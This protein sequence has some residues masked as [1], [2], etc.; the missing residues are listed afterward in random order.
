MVGSL[1][2]D[3]IQY[4]SY[5]YSGYVDLNF[6]FCYYIYYTSGFGFHSSVEHNLL[7]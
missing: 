3:Y 1:T 2:W 5:S 6:F 7:L 4:G